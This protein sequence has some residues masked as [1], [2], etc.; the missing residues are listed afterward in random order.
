ML[1]APVML[2][3]FNRPDSFRQVFEAVRQA[4][5]TQLFLVQDGARATRPDDIPNVQACRD[6]AA[7]IDWPCEIHRNYASENMSCD[8]REYT[9]IDWCFDHVDRL[10]ILEDDCVPT[11]SFLRMCEEL[12]EKYKDDTRVYSISGFAR[13]GTYENY[14]YDYVF[15]KMGAGWGW[16]TW[17]R[18][19]EQVRALSDLSFLDDQNL[20]R[21][22]LE[23]LDDATKATHPEN[24]LQRGREL[25]TI[26]EKTGKIPSWEY[27]VRANLVLNNG[28]VIVPAK[29]LIRYTG[30]SENATHCHADARLL[31]HRTREMLL[32]PSFE[33]DW[34]LRHPPRVLHNWDYEQADLKMAC[35]NP[36]LDHLEALFLK[37]RYGE[38]D[39]L[40][41]SILRRLKK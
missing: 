28:L 19:W 2:L 35:P 1:N 10:I 4:Q 12:L 29:N 3:F 37:I 39:L 8:H 27:L 30:I 11:Q 22:Q 40:K 9:G 13:V 16:A 17:K 5:P 38:F 36:L 6:I 21:C 34:P 25:R 14:P 26:T 20:I 23:N 31:P 32:Q 33:L 7:N 41:Q 24:F 18:T 15:S